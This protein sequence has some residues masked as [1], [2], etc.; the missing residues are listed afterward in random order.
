M[1][2]A[3]IARQRPAMRA[4]FG[5]L[6][7]L[8]Q[9]A[10]ALRCTASPWA[11]A[12]SWR[13]PATWSWPTTRRCSACPRSRS[14]WSP[15]AG[16]TQLALRGLGPGRAVEILDPTGRRVGIDEAE[17]LGIGSTARAPAGRSAWAALELAGQVA[18]NSP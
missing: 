13:C 4:A 12:A 8:P 11:A 9:P 3:D 2:D 17:R 7:A 5:A 6:L 18:A 1:T 15:V 14:A 16:G 10:I